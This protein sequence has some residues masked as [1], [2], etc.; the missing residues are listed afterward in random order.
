MPQDK[1]SSSVLNSADQLE[2]IK[3]VT[4]TFTPTWVELEGIMLVNISQKEK[5]RYWMASLI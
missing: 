2:K 1:T 4:Y 3:I 5:E